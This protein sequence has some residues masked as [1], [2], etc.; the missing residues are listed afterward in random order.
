MPA[1]SIDYGIAERAPNMAVVP[2]SCGWS[3]VGS[4][5]ALPDVRKTDEDGNVCEGESLLVDS[6]G[7]VVLAGSRLVAVVG[8][9]DVV[10]VDAGDAVLVLPKDKSQDVRKVVEALKANRRRASLL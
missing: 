3:D 7:C 9:K 5:N 2:S 4:F 1:M 10:V 8:M 6:Q